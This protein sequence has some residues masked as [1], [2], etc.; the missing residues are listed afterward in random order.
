MGWIHYSTL[1]PLIWA[2][3]IQHQ[4][5]KADV[6]FFFKQWGGVNK[7]KAGRVL[8]GRTW[9]DMS[10]VPHRFTARAKKGR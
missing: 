2:L 4:C 8:N 7:K 10:V 5:S 6:P 3:D 9:D 1:R